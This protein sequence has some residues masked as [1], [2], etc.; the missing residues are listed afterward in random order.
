M[1]GQDARKGAPL[2]ARAATVVDA[3]ARHGRSLDPTLRSQET[4]VSEADRPLL[5]HL[6]FGTVRE[7]WQ[8]KAWL[9]VLLERPLKRRDRIVESLILVGLYQLAR[10]RI[11]THAAVSAT[12]D[13]ARLLERPKLAGLVN[14]VLRRFDR[15]NLASKEPAAAEAR[16]NHPRWIIDRVMADWPGQG[17]RVLDANNDRAP[18]WLRVDTGRVSVDEYV[19]ELKDL[20]MAASE[21]PGSAIRLEEPIPVERLPGFTAGRVSVQD[22]AA[23]LAAPWLLD[24]SGPAPRILDAC[25]APGNKTAHLLELAGDGAELTAIDID[26]ERLASVR[27]NLDRTGRAAT[28]LQADASKPEEWWNGEPFDRILLD[29][30]CSAS[31]VIRRHPD[32]KLL[33]RPGDID[34]LAALQG[35]ILAALWPLVKPGGRLLYV[36]CSVFAAENDEVVAGFLAATPDAREN[37]VLPNNNI[38]D[39]MQRKACGYQVLPGTDGLDGFYFACLEKRPAGAMPETSEAQPVEGSR[40]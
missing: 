26:A 13:A 17:S 12:V 7:H 36:T 8:L 11:P 30:P 33:R 29:A 40:A 39:V 25:A 38:R 18:M 20:G 1:A 4:G 9:E 37:D 34:R 32:I 2:R 22:A 28:V 24:A 3:V 35:R 15:E 23:Q 14:A 19:T 6:C 31:G 10:T 5:A 27:Q 21:G 16:Y